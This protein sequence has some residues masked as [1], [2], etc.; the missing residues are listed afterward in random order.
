VRFSLFF[1]ISVPESRDNVAAYRDE[2]DQMLLAETLG[3]EG[4]WI[5][6]HHF[7]PYGTV[8]SAIG[9]SAY[10]AARTRRIRIGQAVN[11]LPFVHPIR[12]AE[13]AA[14][15]DILSEGRLNFGIGRGYSALEYGGLGI[16]MDESRQRFDESIEIILEAWTK[17]AFS[18][19]GQFFRLPRVAIYPLPLQKPHPADLDGLHEPAD[20][21]LGGR[22]RL[23]LLAGSY[24]AA[25][26][27]DGCTPRLRGATVHGSRC[28]ELGATAGRFSGAPLRVSR[29]GRSPGAP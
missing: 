9:L 2:I 3:F 5:G 15:V 21:L 1:L 29:R 8:G 18:Y 6:E 25:G 10:A 23:R 22:A 13:D 27:T 17:P 14:M 16:S 11:V 19:S 24:A 28:Q 26:L 20:H 12:L 7:S 4:I